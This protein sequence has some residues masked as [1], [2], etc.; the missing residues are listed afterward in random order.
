MKFFTKDKKVKLLMNL[1]EFNKSV[2][3]VKLGQALNI[4]GNFNNKVE[5]FQVKDSE[6][7]Y[8]KD[9]NGV[10][11]IFNLITY[12][13]FNNDKLEEEYYLKEMFDNK[14]YIF[15]FF[16]EFKLQQKGF[17]ISDDF[18]LVEYFDNPNT[19]YKKNEKYSLKAYTM[20]NEEIANI[21]L[22]YC[23]SLESEKNFSSFLK[24]AKEIN[25]DYGGKIIIDYQS[26]EMKAAARLSYHQIE[27]LDLDINRS[28]DIVNIHYY[29]GKLIEKYN[30]IL[31]IT[32]QQLHQ[33]NKDITDEI[34]KLIKKD[35]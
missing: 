27:Y 30:R 11:Y 24:L 3:A 17:K 32:P 16:K 5:I 26:E 7:V 19:I 23:M 20:A 2:K 33:D 22:D 9:K 28:S 21:M 14:F 29:D 25:E 6:D 4:L 12:I 31:E 1:F 10:I 15:N 18:T 35:K 13:Y 34:K 8:V